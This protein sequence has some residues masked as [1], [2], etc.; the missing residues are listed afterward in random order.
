MHDANKQCIIQHLQQR[1]LH[2]LCHLPPRPVHHPGI[3]TPCPGHHQHVAHESLHLI[4]MA[5]STTGLS[6]TSPL[7]T[8]IPLTSPSK[9]PPITLFLSPELNVAFQFIVWWLQSADAK[10][11]QWIQTID[12]QVSSATPRIFASTIN[13]K[14][15]HLSSS[16]VLPPSLPLLLPLLTPQ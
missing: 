10:F 4:T 9:P 12:M 16:L 13:P 2:I 8:T 5:I 1:H 3:Q 14:L 11:G 6:W 15:P 7:T